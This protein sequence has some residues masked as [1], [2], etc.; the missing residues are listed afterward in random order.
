MKIPDL[1]RS[2]F[3]CEEPGC[4]S[5]PFSTKANRDRHTIQKHSPPTTMFCGKIR[6]THESNN[7]RHTKNCLQCRGEIERRLE[8]ELRLKPLGG[9]TGNTTSEL[10]KSHQKPQQRTPLKNGIPFSNNSL[11]RRDSVLRSITDSDIHRTAEFP[12]V[13]DV[14]EPELPIVLQPQASPD[15]PGSKA[16]GVVHHQ[17]LPAGD[18]F[19]NGLQ[20]ET[21]DS[22]GAESEGFYIPMVA[23]DPDD[24]PAG[25]T[26]MPFFDEAFWTRQGT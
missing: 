7:K 20:H 5:K 8:T 1:N 13:E 9:V 18:A 6:A 17:T 23:E 26:S 22:I 10:L 4:E 11:E 21:D 12:L 14:R 24:I 25:C 2:G 19:E 16:L 3:L 15:N